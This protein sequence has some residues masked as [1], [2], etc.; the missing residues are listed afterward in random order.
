MDKSA[1]DKH[2]LIYPCLGGQCSLSLPMDCCAS[3]RFFLGHPSGSGRLDCLRS[4]SFCQVRMSPYLDGLPMR[5]GK[6]E[7]PWRPRPVFLL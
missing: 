4:R 6:V 7:R 1:S 3:C 5:R 2:T